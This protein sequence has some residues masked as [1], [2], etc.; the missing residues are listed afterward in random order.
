MEI[1]DRVLAL[2]V[3][4]PGITAA[5]IRVALPDVPGHAIAR[6]IVRMR[7]EGAIE[8]F[9]WGAYRVK[10]A[11]EEIPSVRT[12]AE[13]RRHKPDSLI[14]PCPLARLMAGR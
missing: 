12:N 7:D 11:S 10:R 9:T 4:Q 8:N 13:I 5:E 6:S 1:A 3:F 2:I 14:R